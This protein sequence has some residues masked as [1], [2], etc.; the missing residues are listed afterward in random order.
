MQKTRSTVEPAAQAP[1]REPEIEA[2]TP[3]PEALAGWAVFLA[4]AVFLVLLVRIY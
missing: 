4:L 3:W 1:A 2:W